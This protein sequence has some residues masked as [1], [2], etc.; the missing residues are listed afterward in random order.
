MAALSST[1]KVSK[2]QL[3]KGG[4][5]PA[6]GADARRSGPAKSA[7]TRSSSKYLEWTATEYQRRWRIG[8]LI[9]VVLV[10][11]W[12]ALLLYGLGEW[13]ASLLTVVV[14][15]VLI[16][17]WG[18]KPRSWHYVITD[19]ELRIE[20]LHPHG[21]GATYPLETFRPFAV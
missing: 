9:A 11:L 6:R 13:S 17:V 7:S 15:L 16:T 10:G 18:G 14:T 20:A 19:S 3:G 21:H 1:E 4:G 12:L 8:R 2:K 5:A